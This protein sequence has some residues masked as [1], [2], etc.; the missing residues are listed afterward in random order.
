MFAEEHLTPVLFENK[1]NSK[2]EVGWVEKLLLNKMT[3]S[4]KNLKG[5]ILKKLGLMVPLTH[6]RDEW[7]E[8][9]YK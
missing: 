7:N 9:S 2:T 3:L 6:T 1:K 4:K 8:S 5:E